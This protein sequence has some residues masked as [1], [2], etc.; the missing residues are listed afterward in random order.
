MKKNIL[1]LFFF[2]FPFS[3]SLQLPAETQVLINGQNPWPPQGP[4][5]DKFMRCY[6]KAKNLDTSVD[7]FSKMLPAQKTFTCEGGIHQISNYLRELKKDPPM[8]CV[9]VKVQ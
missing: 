2:L 3:F 7:I 1:F 9:E 8:E 5:C 4:R 6:D